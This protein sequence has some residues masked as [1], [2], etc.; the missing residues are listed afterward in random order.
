MDGLILTRTI[1][2]FLATFVQQVQTSAQAMINT[3]GDITRVVA[4]RIVIAT[5][6]NATRT[7]HGRGIAKAAAC[8]D[9][10]CARFGI[11]TMGINLVGRNGS[12]VVAIGNPNGF[13]K[14]RIPIRLRQSPKYGTRAVPLE[15]S[16]QVAH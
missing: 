1:G 15:E 4:S 7:N 10:V 8:P 16:F 13:S 14:Y 11:I 2:V 5:H 9:L 12:P 3:Y 6:V